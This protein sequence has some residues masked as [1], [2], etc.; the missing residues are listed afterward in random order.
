MDREDQRVSI[1]VPTYN[2]SG[3]IEKQLAALKNQTTRPVEIIVID[4]SSKDD[5]AQKARTSGAEVVVIPKEEFDHG[6]TRTLGCRKAKGDILVYLT[7][8][9]L[10]AD[11]KAIEIL[12]KPLR[13]NG[14]VGASFGR[15]IPYPYAG[16][17]GAHLRLFNYPQRSHTRSL[18]DKGEFGIKTAF[19]SN[20]FAGYRRK[21][22]EEI[23]FFK[24]GLIFGEDAVAGAKLLLAG[25][26]I[27][28]VAEALVYHSHN[29]SLSQDF[30]RYFDVGVFHQT[31]NWM[32]S[33]FGKPSGEGFKYLLSEI[34]YLL[35]TRK[36]YLVPRSVLT[37]V[38]KYAAY[39]LGYHHGL[40]P[41]SLAQKLSMNRN[42]WTRKGKKTFQESSGSLR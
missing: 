31:Q 28:Y 35:R 30:K 32:V 9:A 12:I 29:Y 6:A 22:L 13:K 5:T 17:L 26:R 41:R 37:N 25:Y 27:S 23:G 42:W 40:L 2:A 39:S 38:S 20:S 3:F 21:T 7:Q 15:Q 4:S 10:P 19:L 14:E 18:E 36:V 1:I 16:P 34:K 33:T 24:E 11:E 8:D